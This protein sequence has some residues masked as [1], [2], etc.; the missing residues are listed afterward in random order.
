MTRW[1]ATVRRPGAHVRDRPLVSSLPVL[2]PRRG[3]GAGGRV[4]GPVSATDAAVVL[5]GHALP[6]PPS[7]AD[8]HHRLAHEGGDGFHQ[9]PRILRRAAQDHGT[10]APV[11]QLSLLGWDGGA[12]RGEHDTPSRTPLVRGNH[13]DLLSLCAGGLPLRGGSLPHAACRL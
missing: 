10:V 11:V 6:D 3:A 13:S 8:T 7:R 5:R 12:I 9:A 4:R 2:P 1:E